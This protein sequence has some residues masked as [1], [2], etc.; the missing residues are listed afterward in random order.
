MRYVHGKMHGKFKFMCKN[1][2]GWNASQG[3]SSSKG[4]F[5]YN[6]LILTNIQDVSLQMEHRCL[7]ITLTMI[8]AQ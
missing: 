2:K 5:N 4:N 1:V 6:L 3:I 8:T 7:F